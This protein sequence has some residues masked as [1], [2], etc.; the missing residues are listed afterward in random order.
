MSGNGGLSLPTDASSSG[1][2]SSSYTAELTSS[3]LPLDLFTAPSPTPSP[4]SSMFSSP[5]ALPRRDP[6]AFFKQNSS[7]QLRQPAFG[8]SLPSGVSEHQRPVSNPMLFENS[9]PVSGL[10][11]SLTPQPAQP[12]GAASGQHQQQQQQQQQ[13]QQQQGGKKDAFADLVDLMS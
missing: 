2:S 7:Q 6:M 4:G 12:N 3:G 11:Y 8:G 1:P 5:T 9:A 13:H 10:G